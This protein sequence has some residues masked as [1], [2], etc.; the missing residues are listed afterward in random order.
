MPEPNATSEAPER[1]F[2]L[3]LLLSEQKVFGIPFVAEAKT[4][5]F[6]FCLMVFGLYGFHAIDQAELVDANGLIVMLYQPCRGWYFGDDRD[7]PI[8]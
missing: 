8:P 7:K 5:P 4:D 2:T 1:A 3:R 6:K